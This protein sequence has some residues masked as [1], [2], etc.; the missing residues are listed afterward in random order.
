MM[1]GEGA[2]MA[3][4][5]CGGCGQPAGA[6]IDTVVRWTGGGRWEWS[7][8]FRQSGG[9]KEG[10]GSACRAVSQCWPVAWPGGTV[11][12]FWES[13]AAGANLEPRSR[14]AASG[15]RGGENWKGKVVA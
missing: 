1:A 3:R 6:G 4:V 11:L 10:L 13:A 8:R 9:K 15:G 2:A 14:L 5:L 12:W 7:D